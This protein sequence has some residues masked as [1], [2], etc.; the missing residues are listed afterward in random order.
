[1]R[2]ASTTS[3]PRPR[4]TW[5]PLPDPRPSASFCHARASIPTD[6]SPGPASSST[7]AGP[8]RLP[9][10][11]TRLGPGTFHAVRNRPRRA[12]LRTHDPGGNRSQHGQCRG[13]PR[14]HRPRHHRDR[15]ACGPDP[16]S[17]QPTSECSPTKSEAIL[18]ISSS[19]AARAPGNRFSRRPER[20]P[21][22]RDAEPPWPNGV[23]G[24]KIA[25]RRIRV[26]PGWRLRGS[27]PTCR[28][29]SR[30]GRSPGVD[31]T[32]AGARDT[33]SLWLGRACPRASPVR[34]SCSRD[35]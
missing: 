9:P 25:R 12:A 22:S 30:S 8:W 24:T 19:A 2:G 14:A 35:R 28:V 26:T 4:P 34:Y 11:A 1:M 27:A 7:K 33:F 23:E 5:L 29:Q 18:L 21:S 20:P 15:Q 32:G 6:A 10:T 17:P 3:R 31:A 13:A 16:P